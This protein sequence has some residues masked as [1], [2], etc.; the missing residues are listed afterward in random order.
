MSCPAHFAKTRRSSLHLYVFKKHFDVV[1][2][3]SQLLETWHSP[4]AS[5][6]HVSVEPLASSVA[7]AAAVASAVGAALGAEIPPPAVGMG[8]PSRNVV[9]AGVGRF[10]L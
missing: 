1:A 5:D 4:L 10:A 8:W 2:F 9:G 6:E 3:H 7:F